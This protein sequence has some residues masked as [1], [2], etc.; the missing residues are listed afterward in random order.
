[1]RLT[2]CLKQLGARLSMARTS[3]VHGLVVAALALQ[4]CESPLSGQA[5]PGA[6]QIP[7]QAPADG[8]KPGTDPSDKEVL[9]PISVL[10]TNDIHGGVEPQL[11]RP[12]Q[13]RIGGLD[14]FAGI[15]A[16]IRKGVESRGGGVVVVDAGDQFQ[17]TLISNFNEGELVFKLFDQIGYD[18]V[19]PGNH[20]Y[21]FGPRGWLKDRA[22]SPDENPREV[23]E[24]LA[25]SVRFP[26]ISANTYLRNSLVDTGSGVRLEVASNS[27][28]TSS[29]SSIDWSK[30]ARPKFL[31]PYVIKDVRGIKVALIGLD[32]PSTASMT[33]ASNVSD[34]CFR[35]LVETYADV[36]SSIGDQA[37]VFVLV[38]HGA[39]SPG[40]YELS[41]WVRE[42][43]RKRKLRLD[44]VVA[45]HTHMIQKSFVDDVPII[46]SGAD[47][48]R[49]GRIDFYFDRTSRRLLK[50][51]TEVVSGA[52]I[53]HDVCD[54]PKVGF[55]QKGGAG[56]NGLA[57]D[58][59]PVAVD[60]K[61][62]ELI[63][64]A[65]E[66]VRPLAE[67]RLFTAKSD[68][69][70]NR[71]SESAMA[72][73]LTDSLRR[74]S[75]AEVSFM[76][77]GGIR[78]E[79][80]A[81]EV[82]YEQLFKVLPFG[83][84]AVVAGPM[85]VERMLKLLQRSIETCG[86]YGALMQSGL[87]VRFT[88]DCTANKGASDPGARLTYVETLDG[89]LILD[90]AIGFQKKDRS[91]KVA[92][93]DFLLDGGSGYTDF[94]GTPKTAELG[95]LRERLAEDFATSRP[96]LEVSGELDGRWKEQQ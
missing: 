16:S 13:S 3:L 73:L 67:R 48:E 59:V 22:T 42:I 88:R 7:G 80:P 19:V 89:E 28:A 76:N 36:V 20:D 26:L 63:R 6:P 37:D 56:Y 52:A 77:T 70:R 33:T 12:T 58:Q 39:D 82:T 17:G 8:S 51:R 29:Q 10:A 74:T 44:A 64:A 21:D 40:N 31:K 60:A 61:A 25:A 95:I 92:T 27:C 24:G 78:D 14:L 32:N 87:R 90:D 18:A 86:E 65:R 2:F 47:G 30:A 69:K 50:G 43:V 1:M 49:F 75:G 54:E 53:L 4:A 41:N 9:V 85:P 23:L 84:Q 66:A 81:G 35:S 55:C 71:T 94:R 83:N 38:V 45:G 68:I 62:T 11:H 57:Y 5:S 34:L 96:S 46:Q 72:N 15:V 91:F 79:I 93:L